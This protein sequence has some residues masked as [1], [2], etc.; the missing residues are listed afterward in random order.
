MYTQEIL[1]HTTLHGLAEELA[2]K[3][4]DKIAFCQE[5]DGKKVTR[6][7]SE[8]LKDTEALSLVF[9]KRYPKGHIALLMHG[10]VEFYMLFYAIIMSGGVVIPIDVEATDDEKVREILHSDSVACFYSNRCAK[11][12]DVIR[13]RLDGVDLINSDESMS[14]LLSKGRTLDG[15][16]FAEDDPG[17]PAAIF[18]TSGTTGVNKGAVLSQKAIA[19]VAC[20]AGC[21]VDVYESVLSVLPAHHTYG[22]IN[23]VLSIYGL[24]RT[25]Y[26]TKNLKTFVK[27]LKKYEPSNLF[28]VPMFLQTMYKMIWVEAEKQHK[29]KLLKGMLGASKGLVKVSNIFV[30]PIYVSTVISAV[31]KILSDQKA[32]RKKNGIKL[33]A[34]TGTMMFTTN[35]FIIPTYI[36]TMSRALWS[37]AKIQKNSDMAQQ[38]MLAQHS[39]GSIQNDMRRAIFKSVIDQFGGNLKTITSGGAPLD[40]KLQRGFEEL[41]IQVLNGY[42]ITECSPLVTVN[43]S[44]QN[45]YGTVGKALPYN[46]IKVKKDDPT[47][48]GEVCVRGDNVMLGY[49]KDDKATREVIKKGW[50]YTGD[51]G[52]IDDDDYLFIT[53]RKKNMIAL[54]SGENVYPEVI[55]DKLYGLD[56]VKDAVVLWDERAQALCAHVYFDPDAD[57][58]GFGEDLKEINRGFPSYMRIKKTVIRDKEFEKT[59]TKKIKRFALESGGND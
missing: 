7:Y 37:Q 24:A 39:L 35:L 41:G 30:V 14:N 2:Y 3:H 34:I 43:I 38:V 51:I 6:T 4:R 52:Y 18:Y 12:V 11:K 58:S 42:G 40:V 16:D 9:R 20:K 23:G 17:A 10:S 56:Y 19:S 8:F 22:C 29:D 53:G 28:L 44:K 57:A 59:S 33:N 49:Y 45:R 50:F 25:V 54:P 21:H 46:S 15:S 47:G 13:D 31:A 27:D 48:V 36:A 55:E 1:D 32:E 5:F 26:F